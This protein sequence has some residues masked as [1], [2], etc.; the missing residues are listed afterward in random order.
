M[1]GGSY[2]YAFGKIR[3]LA[4][5]VRRKASDHQGKTLRHGFARLLDAVADAAYEL[6]WCD[7]GDTSWEQA[8]PVLRKV[9]AP[10][11]VLG[12]AIDIATSAREGLD[13]A[14]R[15]AKEVQP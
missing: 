9:V 3:D 7:S 6:E 1:S 8:E 13:E 12:A 5:E 10:H 15:M 14:I 2:D 4:E 11:Y